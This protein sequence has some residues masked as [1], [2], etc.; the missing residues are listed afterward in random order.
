MAS[1]HVTGFN[2]VF[3]QSLC[4]HSCISRAGAC[5]AVTPDLSLSLSL[6]LSR[7]PSQ[8][9]RPSGGGQRQAAERAPPQQVPHR[10]QHGQRQPGGVPGPGLPGPPAGLRGLP[11]DPGPQP[12]PGP[13]GQPRGGPAG[14]QGGGVPGQGEQRCGGDVF[15]GVDLVCQDV[16][17]F[18]VVVVLF[19]YVYFTIMCWKGVQVG[20]WM[21]KVYIWGVWG[22][23]V[24]TLLKL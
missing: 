22:L 18:V 14:Q 24:I 3:M 2:A 7:P 5:L 12:G 8:G 13:R 19:V 4:N 21:Y 9:Q 10:Q 15:W 17:D 16:T 23:Y 11:G 6:S 1:L 20:G